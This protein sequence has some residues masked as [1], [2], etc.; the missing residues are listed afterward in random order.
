M[1]ALYDAILFQSIQTKSFQKANTKK[2]EKKHVNFVMY[3]KL[4]LYEINKT[5]KENV[6]Y[7]W[8]MATKQLQSREKKRTK[9]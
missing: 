7:H 8:N 6:A 2:N 9:K 5:N 4:P 1:L 3:I